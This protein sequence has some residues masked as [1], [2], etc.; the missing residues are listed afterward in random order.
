MTFLL[1]N[2]NHSK[3]FELPLIER[4]LWQS[5][6]VPKYQLLSTAKNKL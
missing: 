2:F 5:V 1:C 3:V 4:P 6:E